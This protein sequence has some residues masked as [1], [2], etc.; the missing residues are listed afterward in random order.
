MRLPPGRTIELPRRGKVF[1]RE[2][3][4]PAAP[5]VLLLHGVAVTAD[6]NWFGAFGPLRQH[7]R[8]VAPDLRGHGR[9]PLRGRFRLIDCA[10][11]VAAL[12]ETLGLERVIIVG[13]SMGGLVA[14]LTWQRHRRLVAGLVLCATARNFRGSRDEGL[15]SLSLMGFTRA[16]RFNP[17]LPLMGSGVLASAV[18]GQV[19]HS[20]LRSWAHTEMERTSLATT[21]DAFEEV[22]RFTSHQWIGDVDVPTAVLITRSDH[23]VPPSRQR[24]LAAA[25]RAVSVHEIDG[26]HGV[27]LDA[28]GRFGDAVLT[29][30]RSVVVDGVPG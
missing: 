30:C 8:V 16:M 29:A 17:F 18:L 10:D 27:C 23:V 28:P 7:F 14:Q 4:G 22:A 15:M 12:I 1:V 3:G 5:T 6:L 9:T 21:S 25:I 19:R 13:Y 24:R 11:D 2:D 26:D 20:G